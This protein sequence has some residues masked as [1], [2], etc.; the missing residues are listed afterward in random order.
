MTGR[1]RWIVGSPILLRALY[2]FLY[3][4]S[5]QLFLRGWANPLAIDGYLAEFLRTVPGWMLAL[6]A[7]Y[8][9]G[10][11]VSALCCLAGRPLA[12][13]L[14]YAGAFAID[15]PLWIWSYQSPATDMVWNGYASWLDMGFNVFDL[16][17]IVVLVFVWRASRA[18][19]VPEPK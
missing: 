12:A 13:L 15:V 2:A 16:S 8:A 14:V 5:G 19:A 18:T 11:L 7:V 9:T 3:M 4:V 10:Y 17:A 6:W 1:S